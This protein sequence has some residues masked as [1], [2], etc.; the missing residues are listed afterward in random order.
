MKF[1]FLL[2]TVFL[3]LSLSTNCFENKTQRT[4]KQ[5][6]ERSDDLELVIQKI[7]N[8]PNL[9]WEIKSDSNYYSPLTVLKNKYVNDDLK[10]TKSWTEVQL[11][12]QAEIRQE[13]IEHYVEFLDLTLDNDTADFV[14]TLHFEGQA[15]LGEL[16][17]IDSVWTTH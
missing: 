8:D 3:I 4:A 14:F 1:I 16:I 7:I 15:F 17:R 2:L 13:K 6:L 9:D 11:L 5:G 10:L 12:T